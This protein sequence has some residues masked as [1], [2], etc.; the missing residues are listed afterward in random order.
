MEK[1]AAFGG[2]CAY[3]CGRES[4]ATDHI[5]PVDRG[6]KSRPGNLVPACKP[7]NSSKKAAHPA[8]WIE[9]GYAAFPELWDNLFGLAAWQACDYWTDEVE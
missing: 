2:L 8:I 4:T 1:R 9:R 5:W 3:G 6:G 7:C